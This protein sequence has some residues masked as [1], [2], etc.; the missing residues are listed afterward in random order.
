MEI[1]LSPHQ[2][3]F[4]RGNSSEDVDVNSDEVQSIRDL[5]RTSKSVEALTS[6][7]N[8]VAVSSKPIDMNPPVVS[9]DGSCPGDAVQDIDKKIRALKKKIRLAEAQQQKKATEKMRAEELEK[10][11]K[12]EGWR[13]ELKLLESKKI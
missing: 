4:E 3:A 7:M 2:A 6:Q 5:G 11:R 13:E 10:I 12:L 9:V 8:E 1:W